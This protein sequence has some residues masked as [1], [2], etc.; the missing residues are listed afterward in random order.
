MF[1]FCFN[2]KTSSDLRISDWI[3]DVC[4]SDLGKLTF[5]SAGPGNTSHLSAEMFKK[6]TGID[7]LHVPYKGSGPAVVALLAGEVSLMFD[8]ISTSLPQV[9][10]GKLK[11]LAVTS[12]TRSP[13]LPDVPTI[14]E[15]GVPGF[16]VNGWRSE[17]HT[18]ELQS[19][20]RISYAVFCLKKK[21]NQSTQAINPI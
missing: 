15:S 11:A 19:L 20:M 3:S 16:V 17:E 12:E 8:S 14:H 1:F 21:T 18:S 2:Q 5:A 13:L 6:A 9:K 4:S 10:A 7:M